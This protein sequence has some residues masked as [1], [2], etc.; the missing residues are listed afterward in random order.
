MAVQ[1]LK[2]S[3]FGSHVAPNLV[4]GAS[5]GMSAD[6]ARVRLCCLS[7][8]E[9]G[10]TASGIQYFI[11]RVRKT[12]P[13]ATVVV[14]LWHVRSDSQLLAT[15]RSTGQEEQIV[16]SIGELIALAQVLAAREQRS[17]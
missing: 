3:G 12:M 7:V 9:E 13:N 14:C 5:G 4:L 8:L 16:L 10:S 17:T 15:L 11:R 2:A 6:L 1:A